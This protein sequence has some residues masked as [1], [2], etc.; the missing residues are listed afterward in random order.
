MSQLS[1]RE[2]SLGFKG[3]AERCERSGEQEVEVL[4]EVV[5]K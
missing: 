3:G 1:N 5:A 4:E 2:W